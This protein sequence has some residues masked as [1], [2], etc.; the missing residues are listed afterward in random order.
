M[1]CPSH[2]VTKWR[3]G[4]KVTALGAGT[5]LSLECEA[6]YA[7]HP[8]EER[9]SLFNSVTDSEFRITGHHI[10]SAGLLKD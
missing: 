8:A 1:I 2:K 7:R 4:K 3:V 6:T 9:F 10:N 5:T